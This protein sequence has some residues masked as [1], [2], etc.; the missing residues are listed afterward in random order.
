MVGVITAA[1]AAA[2]IE[3]LG[4]N[5]TAAELNVLDGNSTLTTVTL[6]SSDGIIINDS[7]VMK[8]VTLTSAQNYLLGSLSIDILSDALIEDFSM[9]IGNDPSGT[10]DTAQFNIADG[11]T[12]LDA[13]T[14]GEKNI[15][16]GYSALTVNQG[17][18]DYTAV[19][20]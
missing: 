12:G 7:G 14:T 19:G 8:Q 17:G 16:V 6:A 2:A 11:A 15:A 4:V 10:T 1:D 5:S 18:A 3:A 9:Y 13:V 20:F